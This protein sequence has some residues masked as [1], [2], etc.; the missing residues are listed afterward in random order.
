[1]GYYASHSVHSINGR[2]FGSRGVLIE[3]TLPTTFDYGYEGEPHHPDRAGDD[4]YERCVPLILAVLAK[5][6]LPGCH[7]FPL[8]YLNEDG[9]VTRACGLYVPA[10]RLSARVVMDLRRELGLAVPG[11]T[12][13]SG[14]SV[15][16]GPLP[17][18]VRQFPRGEAVR[19]TP[20]A[21]YG[22]PEYA[23]TDRR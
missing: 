20:H 18:E 2:P 19:P 16:F 6:D 13:T 12:V 11:L 1:M 10:E 8:P 17:Q 21:V 15:V 5:Y 23:G 4:L 3:L 14:S 9:T 22:D 7:A